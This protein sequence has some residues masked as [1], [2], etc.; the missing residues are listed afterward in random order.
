M[1]ARAKPHGTSA[2]QPGNREVNERALSIEEK[3][4]NNDL[5][6]RR[7]GSE[8]GELW[9]E[10]EE[11]QRHLRIEH[12][13]HDALRKDDSKTR[14]RQTRDIAPPPRPQQEPKAKREQIN[15]PHDADDVVSQRHGGEQRGQ[16][17][18]K[19]RYVEQESDRN[20]KRGEDSSRAAVADAACSD[21][22]HVRTGCQIERERRSHEQ[23]YHLWTRHTH[24]APGTANA[25][26]N[27]PPRSKAT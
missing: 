26:V 7:P 25:A 18:R 19:R 1:R 17:E 13:R 3:A 6:H 21:I 24:R 12:I 22:E 14:P 27:P 16:A 9:Q 23:K 5:R 20:A 11:E 15:R 8:I 4:Q 2:S 10:R